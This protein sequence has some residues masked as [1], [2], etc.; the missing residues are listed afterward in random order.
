MQ[1]ELNELRNQVRTLKRLIFISFGL[2]IVGGLLAATSLESIPDVIQAKKFEVVN[3]S[4]KVIVEISAI[5][6]GGKLGIY[7]NGGNQV[8]LIGAGPTG[9]A[10]GIRNKAG[11]SVAVLVPNLLG[12]ALEIRNK[13]AE[14]VVVL[15]TTTM[16]GVVSVLNNDTIGVA[17]VA[18]DK[19][20]NGVL[21][22]MDSKGKPTSQHP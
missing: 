2:F 21:R 16:G 8:A 11:K 3:D 10:L 15:S 17:G 14:P 1:I 20:G 19:N 9:G 6:D 18:A 12:G 13:E 7:E 4:G 5:A 22:L